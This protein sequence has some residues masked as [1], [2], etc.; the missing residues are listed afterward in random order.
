MS[1]EMSSDAA[2]CFKCGKKYSRRKG[3]F[4]VSYAIQHKGVGHIHICKDCIDAMY[5]TYLSQCNNAKDAVRQMCRKLDLYWSENVYDIVE[6][7]STTRSM[8]T[9]YIAKIN[10]VSYAGKSY[11]DTLSDEG[12]LWN[13]A[14]QVVDDSGRTDTALADKAHGRSSSDDSEEYE[15]PDDVVEFWGMGY[16]PSMY[17]QLEQRRQYWMS[18]F[19]DGIELDIG[20]EALI[21]Q[22]CSLEID[23]NRDRIEGR[24]VDKSVNALNT[25]LGSANLKP[26]QKKDDSDASLENTPFGVWIR[27]WETQR[28]VPDP[29]PEL[30]DVD[31]IV[32][33]ISI[34]FLGHLCKMLGIK[35]TYCK[36]Y[37]AEIAKMRVD[38]PEYEDEDDEAMFNDIFGDDDL[39]DD[40]S[41]QT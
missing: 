1:I 4:P 26:T 18:R 21:R 3:F 22:I 8:M 5:N 6:R 28:P 39:S 37:E 12:T 40:D 34:W 41:E 36:L 17:Q 19:P 16:P 23:I 32:R 33:Y 11:D 9:Q 7:K 15:V 30:E 25:L 27:K 31:G 2:V 38:R 10:S 14:P 24:A 20:T 29:D 13:F 35:N